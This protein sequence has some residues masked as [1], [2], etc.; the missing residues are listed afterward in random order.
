[1]YVLCL[2]MDKLRMQYFIT[3]IPTAEPRFS[4]ALDE[5]DHVYM[6]ITFCKYIN[7]S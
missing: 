1:M 7:R 4:I 6:D 2:N 5:T 3:F